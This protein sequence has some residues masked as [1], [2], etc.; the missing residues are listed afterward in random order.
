[1]D[2]ELQT[3]EKIRFRR[4]EIVDLGAFPSAEGQDLGPA[5]PRLMWRAANV[6]V[7]SFAVAVTFLGLVAGLLYV[8]GVSGFGSERLRAEAEKAIS[9]VA[10]IDIDAAIGPAH[11]SLDGSSLV[12]LEVRDVSLKKREDGAPM[13]DAGAIRFGVRFL[14]LLSGN[15][16]LG[17]ASISDARI[18]AAS[19]PDSDGVDWTNVLRNG[20]GLLDPN[21]VVEVVFDRVH[22]AL[23]AVRPGSTD[24][25]HLENVEVVL[26][27]DG[28]VRVVRIVN[29]TL[30]ASGPGKLTFSAATEVD[31]RSV[32]LDGSAVRD[33]IS[34]R[35]S[36][37]DLE[38]AA[39]TPEPAAPGDQASQGANHLGAID[40]K[41]SGQEGIG[42]EPARLAAAMTLH[43][44]ALDLGARGVFTGSASVD[45]MLVAGSGKIEINRLHLASGRNNFD[46]NGAVGPKPPS[47]EAGDEPAYRYELVSTNRATL[48]PGDSPEPALDIIAQISGIYAV[49]SNRLVAE[50]VAISSGQGEALG[51]AAVE[52][53]AGKA[54]GF[55]VAFTVND[56][57]VS[58]VKQLW[59]WLAAGKA[60]LWVLQ[61]VFGGRVPEGRVQ[62]RVLP[63]RLGNGVPLSPEEVSGRFAVEGARFDT[64]GLIPPVRDANGVIEFAGNDV[65][66][67][68]SSGTVYMPSGRSVAASSGTL[69]IK[70][71]NRP[72]VIGALDINVAGDAAAMTELAS[73]DPINAM[74]FVGL[75]PGDFSGTVTGNVKADIPLNK[76]IDR[77]KLGW[78]VALD[79]TDLALAKPFNG[80]TVSD[81]DGTITVDPFKAVISAKARL[82]GAEAEIALLEPLRP[83][84]PERQRKV[85]LTLD[86]KARNAL[87]PGLSLLVSGPMRVELEA[88]GTTQQV[89]AD[90]TNARLDI[91]WAGWSKG[92]G[93][94]AQASFAL[95]KTGDTV[96]LSD[97]ELTGKSFAIEGDVT[98]AKGSL[99]SARF[100]KV[101]LNRGDDVDVSV[102]RTGKGYSVAV[103]GASFDARSLIKQFTSDASTAMKSSGS[104]Q[105]SLKLDVSSLGGFHGER[106]SNV[107]LDYNG[108]GARV[109]GLS[110]AAALGSGGKMTVENA[111]E[112]GRRSLKM[113]SSDAGAILRFLNIYEHMEGG[114]IRLAL[115]G[116]GAGP[117]RGRVDA[118]NFWVV[119]EPKLA[120]IVSTAPAGGDR[121]LNQAVRKDIDTSR[122]QFER[123]AT[124]IDKGNGY[125]RLDN[126]VL[127]GPMIGTTFQ[128]TLYDK[129][130]RMDMTG[131]FMPAYGLNRIFG[132]IPL[133]GVILG[134]GRDRGLIGVTYK[135]EGPVK[136]PQL[137]INPLSVIAPGI[138]RSI[139]EYQ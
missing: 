66:I 111:S 15:V 61:H 39:A 63:G 75:A 44:S 32:T 93:V 58:H 7:V 99:T 119:N 17:S 42:A 84:A 136:S 120:S 138:F 95:D 124:Q 112:G 9:A 82:N 98:L 37:L 24:R 96:K 70:A 57:Q 51:S 139:F 21:R 8:A 125:L 4:D 100:D 30:A 92:P 77:S 67:S 123:G 91:P 108:A 28:R 101:Q 134:N 135:L 5:R 103:E 76:G 83:G 94:A 80:Q 11:L 43:E 53:A 60:R 106:L 48:A 115:A 85:T 71:A 104:G 12:A 1:M 117:M 118:T 20:E 127:R 26:P 27:E 113:Q 132:E 3:H 18:M 87:A 110:V 81:A 102:Q 36:V 19:M 89:K 23:D 56:M 25:I 79:Y 31:G 47:D 34:R 72:P 109:N 33:P 14:P 46:F 107:K 68:L 45:A 116:E 22:R 13:I 41:L 90:L 78:L 52:F 121:S 114:A 16:R 88:R 128:G 65:D 97:F 73:Y 137:Q 29:A 62:F 40:L 86:D 122:V 54:P 69:T 6:V 49:G 130:D 129:N 35:I 50:K 10:G 64:A 131:T 105:V 38:L 126:G 59:P 133:F 74:R 2:H 55:A